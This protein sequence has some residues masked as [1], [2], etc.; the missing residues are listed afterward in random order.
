MMLVFDFTLGAQQANRIGQS[1]VENFKR[2]YDRASFCEGVIYDLIGNEHY[3]RSLSNK[4]SK[5]SSILM[6]LWVGCHAELMGCNI[7]TEHLVGRAEMENIYLYIYINIARSG[8]SAVPLERAK[9]VENEWL[10]GYVFAFVLC[11]IS[12]S[13]PVN[14]WSRSDNATRSRPP[15]LPLKE[16]KKIENKQLRISPRKF[17]PFPDIYRR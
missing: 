6:R 1:V 17:W 11:I 12:F 7:E 13:P 9:R 8:G 16:W 14:R 5:G 2:K 10:A 15:F 3:I 4:T